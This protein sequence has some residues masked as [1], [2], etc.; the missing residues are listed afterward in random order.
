MDH[1]LEAHYTDGNYSEWTFQIQEMLRSMIQATD[2]ALQRLWKRDA[3]AMTLQVPPPLSAQVEDFVAQVGEQ[4]GLFDA[5]LVADAPAGAVALSSLAMAVL[6]KR[7][8]IETI[9][10]LSGRDRNRLAL[11]SDLLSLGALG[12]PNLLV[13]M[14]PITRTSLLENVDARLVSDL[15]G[16][17]LLAAAVKMRDEARFLSGASIKLPPTL[18]VGALISLQACQQI[19]DL[20]SAQFL[21]TLPIQDV[22]TFALALDAFRAAHPDFLRGRPLLVSL[23]LDSAGEHAG[24]SDT[25]HEAMEKMLYSIEALKDLDGVRGF[26]IVL[27]KQSDLALAGS[28][29]S[30]VRSNT[31]GRKGRI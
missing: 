6:F 20:G 24:S 28:V 21:V 12:L 27:S 29:A 31:V 15:D 22:H 7:A 18:Y 14:R 4:A 23:R 17:A 30:E 13:D 26:N 11:Q 3:L 25:V 10:Q 19:D 5:V 9:V 8:G 16:P 2:S 1:P